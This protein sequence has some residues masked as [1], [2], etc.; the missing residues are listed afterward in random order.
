MSAQPPGTPPRPYADPYRI[1][2]DEGPQTIAELR[3]ALARVSPLD[4]AV[5]N[6]R[7]DS[8]RLGAVPA[9]LTE[10]RHVLALR[11]SPEVATAIGDALDG[12]EKTMGMDDFFAS[13]DAS[14]EP[15]E[16][17]L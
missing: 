4:L 14:Y 1:Q 11:T 5:F 15:G 3:A 17:G 7:L 6:A 8:A 9:V 13:L 16:G 2:D 12:H 10:Y